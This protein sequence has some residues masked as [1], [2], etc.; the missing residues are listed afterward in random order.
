M[1]AVLMRPRGQRDAH[2]VPWVN[3]FGII[4]YHNMCISH[5]RTAPLVNRDRLCSCGSPGSPRKSKAVQ[6]VKLLA[7]PTRPL[8]NAWLF[9]N[10]FI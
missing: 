8:L 1:Y 7:T 5:K 3:Q 10:Q 2:M 4:R 9:V 6:S